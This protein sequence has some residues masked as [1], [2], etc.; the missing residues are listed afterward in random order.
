MDAF[1]SPKSPTRLGFHYF[2]DTLHYRESDLHTWLPQLRAL[3]ASWLTL[4]SPLQSAIPE[5]FLSGLMRSDIQP[6]VQFGL[7]PGDLPGLPEIRLL[8]ETYARWGLRYVVLFDRP[9]SRQS[10]PSNAWAQEDLVERFLDKYLPFAQAAIQAGLIPVFPPLE[11][12]GAYWDTAFLKAAVLSL[13]RRRQN[14][15]LDSL[16][17]SGY[18]WSWDHSLNWGC[19]GPGRW[20]GSRPYLTPARQQDQRGF[21]IYDWYQAVTLAILGR[22]SPVILF[23]GGAQRDP[24]GETLTAPHPEKH[25]ALNLNLAR[26]MA[27]EEVIENGQVPLDPVNEDVLCCNLWLL[28]TSP[29]HPHQPHAWFQPENTC[30]PAVSALRQW[31]AS[32]PV[33]PAFIS[34]PPP[35]HVHSNAN[36]HYILLAES[37]LLSPAVLDVLHPLIARDHATLGYSIAEACQARTVTLAGP[38]EAFSEETLNQLSASGCQMQWLAD[39]GTLIA[40]MESQA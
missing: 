12:G 15:L 24:L 33:V 30:L 5:T 17:L 1:L 28:A 3:G 20:P 38:R 40:T 36:T 37:E 6:V 11:P 25:A 22:R 13:V 23:G 10:W 32:Q 34:S 21:R 26:L 2:P 31:V 39:S 16:V 35:A 8:L 9:N 4:L 18:A 7:R 27:G 19:G 29:V 14:Q